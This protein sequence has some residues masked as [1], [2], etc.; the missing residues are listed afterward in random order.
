[1]P[2]R[3]RRSAA[4]GTSTGLVK[5]ALE[6]LYEP[7]YLRRH[8]L[9]GPAGEARLRAAGTLK[10]R[11]L[12]AIEQLGPAAPAGAAATPAFGASWRV[13]RLL[14]LRYVEALP[15]PAVMAHLGLAKSQYYRDH[16]LALEAVASLLSEAAAA[17]GSPPAAPSA[18]RGVAPPALTGRR[19]TRPHSSAERG[20]RRRSRRCSRCTAWSR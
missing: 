17:T 20:R 9:S 19:T 11:L 18:T 7:D 13:R 2:P 6:H 8:P 1:M 10:R 14:E 12:A 3:R 15:P 4:A 5:S 16:A